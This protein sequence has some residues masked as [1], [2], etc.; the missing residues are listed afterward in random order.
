MRQLLHT[1]THLAASP[2]SRTRDYRA[3]CTDR[4]MDLAVQILLRETEGVD[5]SKP[6]ITTRS[7]PTGKPS[8][9]SVTAVATYAFE[10]L[11]LKKAFTSACGAILGC[12]T[13][14]PQFSAVSRNAQV[15]DSPAA[16]I[17]YGVSSTRYQSQ[18]DGGLVAVESRALTYYRLADNYGVLL[19][20]FADQ[21]DL[22]PMSD[23]A[24][25]KRDVIGA[26]VP[27]SVGDAVHSPVG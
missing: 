2:W 16:H 25:V 4:K 9:V 15:I 12:G 8:E 23:A 13:E 21:D 27:C 11:D 20:D 7:V 18:E 10:A 6:V 24:S 26:Y 17:R 22:F 19:W 3:I 1:Y 5:F 14:W